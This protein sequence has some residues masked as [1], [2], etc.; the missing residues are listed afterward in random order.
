MNKRAIARL[1]HQRVEGLSQLGGYFFR[2]NVELVLDG[3]LLEYRP[4]EVHLWHF[5]FPLFDDFG[6]NLLYSNRLQEGGV[7]AKGKLSDEAI[8]EHVVNHPELVDV[9]RPGP[10]ARTCDFL[11]YLEGAEAMLN[12]HARLVFASGL[13]L[14]QEYARANAVLESMFAT[15]ANRLSKRDAEHGASL[16]MR[17]GQSGESAAAL[18]ETVIQKNRQ[19]FG[20][21]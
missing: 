6:E 10:P 20:I 9:L 12:P 1:M 5:R 16:L 15:M 18:L 19:A 14:D 11:E 2:Q 4:Q 3:V 8:V 21:R 17:L 13:V 7:I